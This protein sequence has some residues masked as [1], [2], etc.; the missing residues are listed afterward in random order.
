MNKVSKEMPKD[1]ACKDCAVK[2]STVYNLNPEEMDIL[3]VNS[4]EIKFKKG[5]KIIKQ[6]TFTQNIVFVKGGIV[7][8]HLTGPLNKDE[9]LKIDKG[10]LF[11]GVPDV[12]ANKTHSYS[13]TALNDTSACFIESARYKHLI[14]NNGNFALELINTLS[15]GIVSHY[16]QCVYKMQ[17]QI[18]ATTAEAL[19]YFSDHIFE[20]DEFE[21]PLT[22]VE[23]G[24]YIGTTR[25][26][27]TKIIHDFTMDNI[28]EVE[29]RKFKLINK[30]MLAKISKA[31]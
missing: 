25:E 23:L 7:K 30:E 5:E 4:T 26:T 29:G 13:V 19:L 22:R 11:V 12:F 2:S 14:Q 17:K 20:S 10:P 28:I 6:G 9:I 16:K 21:V 18:T 3:C 31:G 15:K 24:E 1:N 27:I 8:I